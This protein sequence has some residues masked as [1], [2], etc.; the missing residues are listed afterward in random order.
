MEVQPT[1][2]LLQ[3][4]LLNIEGLGRQLYPELDL[5]QTAL[6]YLESWNSKRLNP[7][8]ILNKLQ[9]NVPNWIDQMP[10]LP[11]LR[12]NA[13]TQADQLRSINNT[14]QKELV[15][16]EQERKRKRAN[17]QLAG[18]LSLG[19]GIATLFP[20]IAVAINNA[21]VL[22][23]GLIGFGLYLLCFKE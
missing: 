23:V 6:P 1:L 5:W 14:L 3:K 19:A 13:V 7:L 22:S 8:T 10:D 2:V 12:I 16:K 4:T 21:P 15:E 20:A 11:L 17:A 18:T 9:E